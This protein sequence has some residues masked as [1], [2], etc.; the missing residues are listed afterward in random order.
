MEGKMQHFLLHIFS[1]TE[2]HAH[3]E[4]A[5][6]L[7]S[8]ALGHGLV[9]LCLNAA[10]CTVVGA[11]P[12]EHARG[13]TTAGATGAPRAHGRHVHS[14]CRPR[15]GLHIA[16]GPAGILLPVWP[17]GAPNDLLLLPIS[18]PLEHFFSFSFAHLSASHAPTDPP[19]LVGISLPVWG[20]APKTRKFSTS[21]DLICTTRISPDSP[22]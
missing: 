8:G 22:R 11:M 2:P 7:N 16:R 12:M 3:T 14:M 4:C 18:P 15:D 1:E 21:R 17:L 13:V 10:L 19:S 20:S 9:G 5:G 6:R